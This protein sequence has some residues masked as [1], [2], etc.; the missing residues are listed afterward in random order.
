[1]RV[2]SAV[3]LAVFLI[4]PARAAVLFVYDH[5]DGATLTD[6]MGAGTVGTEFA[7]VR[8]LQALGHQVTTSTVLPADLTPY[9]GVFVLT[10]WSTG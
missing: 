5:D 3:I 2:I 8:A 6:P 10:A 1:M 7:V 4:M 9:E